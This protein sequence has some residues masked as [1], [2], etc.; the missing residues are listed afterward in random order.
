MAATIRALVDLNDEK[1]LRMGT[2]I[3]SAE[4]VPF[5]QI[6]EITA[7]R[8]GSH[9]SSRPRHD[10][11]ISGE[12]EWHVHNRARA[13]DL[14]PWSRAREPRK[15]KRG[16]GRLCV[17]TRKTRGPRGRQRCCRKIPARAFFEGKE[18]RG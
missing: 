17:G 12:D 3:S 8:E 15:S 14:A 6:L 9:G 11:G 13:S 2:T 1:G 5:L 10:N 16:V 7:N 4:T 18:G